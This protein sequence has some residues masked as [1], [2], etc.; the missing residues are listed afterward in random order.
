MSSLW[1][2]EPDKEFQISN[3]EHEVKPI[4]LRVKIEYTIEDRKE[5]GIAT[6]DQ[7]AVDY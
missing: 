3:A 4:G 5:T 6:L 2:N 7:F 1:V